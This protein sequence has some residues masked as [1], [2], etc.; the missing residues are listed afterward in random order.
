[1][2][3]HL[4]HIIVMA[5]DRQA[6]AEFL[7]A[8]LGLDLGAPYGPFL[9]VETGNGVKLD[10]MESAGQP[11]TPQHYAFLVTEADF[12]TIFD[13]IRRAEITYY[14]DPRRAHPGQINHHDG[15][16]GLYFEDPNGHSLEII[17]QPYGS[18]PQ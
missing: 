2:S 12:D 9:P 16:R 15:G 5:A 11:V 8:I 7:A 10:V 4:D 14:A 17:T 18:N 3:V 13:R 1:M 6:T